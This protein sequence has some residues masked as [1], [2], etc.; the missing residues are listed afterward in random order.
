MKQ[1]IGLVSI[2]IL[3]FVAFMP[4]LASAQPASQT[5]DYI[6]SIEPDEIQQGRTG[7]V[8][9]LPLNG[10]HIDRIQATFNEGFFE[11][12]PSVDG[13]WVGFLAVNMDSERGALPLDLYIW[14]DGA[15]QPARE[16][17]TVDVVWGAFEY[18]DIQ[19]PYN[20]EPL[21]SREVNLAEYNELVRVQDRQSD[22][23]FFNYFI[24]P[25]PGPI[26]STF[27]GIRSYNNDMYQG[28]HTGVDFR[29]TSGTP[30]S[31]VADGRI[32]FAQF[33]P[34]HGNHVIIDHGGGVMS[35]Y[36]HFGE[37]IVTPGQLVRQGD[38]IGMVGATGRV[39]GP[40][41]HFELIVN[42]EW[43]DPGQFMTLNIP[44]PDL[45]AISD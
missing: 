40:H 45:T 24:Q 17:E 7:L 35:G 11:L 43:V 44:P 1:V 5:T 39:Q 2:F 8:R 37:I 9:V 21:L 34:I 28:R 19:L 31:A 14:Y 10:I 18:Q 22:E 38:T 13:D 29:A 16:R 15:T 25:V 12:Y 6:I 23:L 30:V 32:I 41:F 27:G 36:S 3:G 4:H 26:I 33:M 42:G 20:L